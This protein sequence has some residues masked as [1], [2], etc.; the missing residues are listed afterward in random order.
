MNRVIAGNHSEL[1][2]E[3]RICIKRNCANNNSLNGQ[4]SKL[5]SPVKIVSFLDAE[6]GCKDWD[7]EQTM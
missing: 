7:R 1:G 5:F 2:Y 4:K 3:A 6:V